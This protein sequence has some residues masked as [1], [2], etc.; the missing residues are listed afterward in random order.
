MECRV[1]WTWN[2]V[3]SQARQG[4]LFANQEESYLDAIVQ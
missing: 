3:F 2:R 1:N 4:A